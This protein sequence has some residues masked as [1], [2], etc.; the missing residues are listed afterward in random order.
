[1]FEKIIFLIVKYGFLYKK[2]FSTTKE[3]TLSCQFVQFVPV[4][5]KIKKRFL[6]IKHPEEICIGDTLNC[7]QLDF[8]SFGNLHFALMCSNVL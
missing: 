5:K 2:L 7:Y 1:M 8:H 3:R 6:S 4:Q